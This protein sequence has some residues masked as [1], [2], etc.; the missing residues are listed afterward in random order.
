[1]LADSKC[2]GDAVSAPGTV[3]VDTPAYLNALCAL[4]FVL[5]KEYTYA[6]RDAAGV[7]GQQKPHT[8]AQA[9]VQLEHCRDVADERAAA[10]ATAAAAA[11]L[12]PPPPASPAA[13][14]PPPPPAAPAAAPPA[15]TPTSTAAVAA[16]VLQA[17][18][19]AA[20]REEHIAAA[21]AAAARLE[22]AAA[23]R[24][25]DLFSAQA[26]S[27]A[28]SPLKRRAPSALP[29]AAKRPNLTDLYEI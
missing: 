2:F 29:V 7:G 10:A 12:Q 3:H 18:L 17:R 19:A 26:A 8:I 11:V 6:E 28:A 25:R 16:S 5:E 1:L 27:A 20:V 4:K 24:E 15:P 23:R 9:I 14:A 13:A 21:K 22:V